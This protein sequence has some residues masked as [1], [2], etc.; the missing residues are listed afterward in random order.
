[1][2]S[3]FTRDA[4]NNDILSIADFRQSPV[5]AEIEPL[6][7]AVANTPGLPDVAVFGV[8]VKLGEI[9]MEDGEV[10]VPV[11]PSGNGTPAEFAFGSDPDHTDGRRHLLMF[12]NL[13]SAYSFSDRLI[14]RKMKF[15][16]LLGCLLENDALDSIVVCTED[17]S[18]SMFKINRDMATL[19]I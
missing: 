6:L 1:M 17:L 7:G 14:I 10:L 15:A 8:A 4:K 3:S 16:E 11:S 18:G 2:N 13:I 12:T 9:V 5:L 19:A